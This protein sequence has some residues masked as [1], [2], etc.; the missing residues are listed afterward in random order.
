MN[1]IDINVIHVDACTY[2]CFLTVYSVYVYCFVERVG[3]CMACCI[4][5]HTTYW[6]TD[7]FIN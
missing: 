7:W 2:M 4:R 3:N 1:S 6:F 5:Q